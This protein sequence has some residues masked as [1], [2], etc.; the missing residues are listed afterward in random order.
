[1][2]IRTLD[3]DE[4]NDRLAELEGFRDALESERENLAEAT[5]EDRDEIA[6]RLEA[7]QDDFGADEQDEL[8][9]LESLR[10]EIGES[11]GKINDEGG[12]FIHENDFKE[13]AQELAE[14]IG[15]IPRDAAWPCR[16]IDWEAAADEL[17]ADYSEVTRNGETY[18]YRS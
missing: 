1:M 12:P 15:A 7:A 2:K 4:L 8:K 10:D 17:R 3:I 13:Y 18:L 14:D 6:G 11:R 16:C 9:Q 5:D